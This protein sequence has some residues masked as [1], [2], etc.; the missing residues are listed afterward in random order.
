[1]TKVRD[2][3]NLRSQRVDWQADKKSLGQHWYGRCWF[4]S[5][6]TVAYARAL[7]RLRNGSIL[8]YLTVRPEWKQGADKVWRRVPTREDALGHKR[9][10]GIRGRD[11]YGWSASHGGVDYRRAAP[12]SEQP[13]E[14]EAKAVGVEDLVICPRCQSVNE[15]YYPPDPPPTA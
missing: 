14:P 11:P 15:L 13:W 1:M 7:N 5:N 6:Q 10:G 3:L 2:N 9:P 12:G 8:W 4:C